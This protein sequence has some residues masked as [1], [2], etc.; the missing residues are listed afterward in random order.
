ML[1]LDLAFFVE[2]DRCLAKVC[3]EMGRETERGFVYV[4]F[5]TSALLFTLVVLFSE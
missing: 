2:A 4:Y 1:T 5:Q 3:A